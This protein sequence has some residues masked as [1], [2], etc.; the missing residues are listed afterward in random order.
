MFR[1]LALWEAE[2]YMR[3]IIRSFKQF[4]RESYKTWKH[5]FNGMRVM[6]AGSKIKC[7]QQ[8]IKKA[9]FQID[10]IA[11]LNRNFA[12]ILFDL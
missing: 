8:L 12:E 5:I 2:N 7:F 10:N 9:Y 1:R 6:E 11:K 3:I 4:F